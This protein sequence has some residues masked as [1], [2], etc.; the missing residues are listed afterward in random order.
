[1]ACLSFWVPKTGRI[2]IPLRVVVG[3]RSCYLGNGEGAV[4]DFIILT[5]LKVVC[6]AAG[7]V[8]C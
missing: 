3:I 6:P 5:P 8:C 7:R 4:I 1:M 2:L